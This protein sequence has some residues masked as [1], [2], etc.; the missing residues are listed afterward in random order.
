VLKCDLQQIACLIIERHTF[1]QSADLESTVMASL[2][3]LDPVNL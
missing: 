3:K 1:I 2:L